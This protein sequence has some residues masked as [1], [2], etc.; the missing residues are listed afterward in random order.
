MIELLIES[1]RS[2]RNERRWWAGCSDATIEGK[3]I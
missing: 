2:E 3:V 1:L